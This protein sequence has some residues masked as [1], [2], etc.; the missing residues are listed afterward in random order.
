[1]VF[2]FTQVDLYFRG[3]VVLSNMYRLMEEN[4]RPTAQEAIDAVKNGGRPGT[5]FIGRFNEVLVDLQLT[6]SFSSG[7]MNVFF[8]DSPR[9]EY[10]ASR[11]CD[12]VISGETFGRSGYG[13]ALQ[14]NSFWTE[15]VTLQLLRLIESGFMETL[16]NKWIL[17]TDKRCDKYLESS[18]PTTLGLENMAG[19][20][21]LV[22]AGRIY[23]IR[24]D[25]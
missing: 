18:F 15:R 19:V 10:E 8:W 2:L 23:R 3:Q 6:A 22:G 20:F 14:K 12:L 11:D 25:F 21:I 16:D 24:W 13:I 5:A 7:D 9:L 17:R 4:N 1:M